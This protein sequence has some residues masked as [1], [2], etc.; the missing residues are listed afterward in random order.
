MVDLLIPWIFV[1]LRIFRISSRLSRFIWQLPRFYVWR[2]R[3]INLYQAYHCDLQI[4]I[5]IVNY[6]NHCCFKCASP[7]NPQSM[8]A[9]PKIKCPLKRYSYHFKRKVVFQPL[10]FRGHA[11]VFFLNLLRIRLKFSCLPGWQ[12]KKT[13]PPVDNRYRSWN[14]AT[15]QNRVNSLSFGG[16][17]S[18]MWAI[19]IPWLFRVY[20]LVN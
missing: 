5:P 18:I 8:F 17:G 20:T 9:T 4:D 15:R 19:K 1:G 7:W 10:F 2:P 13:G 3:W 14:K 11:F 16:W 6:A 12:R